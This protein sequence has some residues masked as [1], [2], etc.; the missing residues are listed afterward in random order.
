MPARRE[1][2][3]GD[4][5]LLT[6]F[7]RMSVLFWRW[8]RGCVVSDARPILA[9][10]EEGVAGDVPVPVPVSVEGFSELEHF[11]ARISCLIALMHGVP[12]QSILAG[13]SCTEAVIS[14]TIPA[15]AE[16]LSLLP[17]L[18]TLTSPF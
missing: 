7:E 2:G 16:A 13:N 10:M 8:K 12:R 11:E 6:R 18:G 3:S 15:I 9:S 5:S 17:C 14:A 4:K 1:R